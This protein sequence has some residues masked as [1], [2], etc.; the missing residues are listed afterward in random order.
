MPLCVK[1][2]SPHI[3]LS[4]EAAA[5]DLFGA[6]EWGNEGD[7]HEPAA[8]SRDVVDG[9]DARLD[10]AVDDGVE[11]SIAQTCGFDFSSNTKCH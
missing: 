2:V 11:E 8:A 9:G 1:A 3:D 4:D 7:G 6:D 5:A 10:S